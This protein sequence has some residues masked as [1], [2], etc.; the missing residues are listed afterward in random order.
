MTARSKP[1]GPWELDDFLDLGKKTGAIYLK[2]IPV[3]ILEHWV[4]KKRKVGDAKL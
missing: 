1:P 4:R 2:A 3:L